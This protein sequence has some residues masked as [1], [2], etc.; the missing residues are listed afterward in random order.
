MAR[1]LV[2]AV[3]QP[4]Q[5]KQGFLSKALNFGKDLGVGIVKSL[6]QTV[7][8]QITSP[9]SPLNP[10][11]GLD[12]TGQA[13][14]PLIKKYIPETVKLPV[15]GETSLRYSP[16]PLKALGQTTEDLL[17]VATSGG[18]G[19]VGKQVAKQGFKEVVEQTAK[20][21]AKKIA[22]NVAM[23]FGVGGLYGASSAIQQKD[24]KPMDVLKSTLFGGTAG[25]LIPR[26]LGATVGTGLKATGIIGKKIAGVAD[27]AASKLEGFAESK[28]A[29]L[30]ER[31]YE[32]VDKPVQTTLQNAAAKTAGAIRI[33]QKT[34]DFLKKEFI[35][36]YNPIKNFQE[37][38]KAQGIDVPD[39]HDMAQSTG[40]RASGKAENK[41][42]DYL[43]LRQGSA[44]VWGK[45]KELAHYLDDLDRLERGNAIAGGRTKEQVTA[46]LQS[47][48][49]SMSP[50]EQA[51]VQKAY[52]ELQGFLKKE[53][54]D[55]SDSGRISP[56]QLAQIQA[57]HP[58]YIPHDVLDFVDEGEL[59]QQAGRSFNVAKSGVDKASGSLREIDDIDNAITR[60][61]FKNSLLN[62][63][64][65]TMAAIVETGGKMGFKPLRTAEHVQERNV[66]IDSLKQLRAER[67]RIRGSIGTVNTA[68]KGLVAK[69]NK[70]N[71]E[72]DDL[73]QK[74]INLFT[75]QERAENPKLIAELT[76]RTD[77]RPVEQAQQQGM[78]QAAVGKE[79]AKFLAR[80]AN[81]VQAEIN[82]TIKENSDLLFGTIERAP[83]PG[84]ARTIS[85]V[86]S[87]IEASQ[88]KLL[89]L[90]QER[91]RSLNPET[92]V[93]APK[94]SMKLENVGPTTKQQVKTLITSKNA[95]IEAIKNRIIAREQKLA[96]TETAKSGTEMMLDSLFGTLKQKRQQIADLHKALGPLRDVEA[97]AIDFK[98]AGFE[99]V[100]Y[101]KNGVREDWLV[102]SDLGKAL[103]GLDGEG[104]SAV[105]SWL[106][107]SWGGKFLTAPARA[108]RKVATGLEATFALVR[109]PARDVQTVMM[110]GRALPQDYAKGLASVIAGKGKKGDELYRLARE[111]GALQGSI[112]KE[113]E[114]PQQ[115]LQAKLAKGN[116]FSKIARPDKLIENAGQSMEEMTRMAVFGRAIKDGKTAQEAAKLARNST[117][118]FGKSGNTLQIINKVVPFLNARVQGFTN[119]ATKLAED[120]TKF[121]RRGMYSAAIPAA[122]LNGHNSQYKSYS[123][124]PSYEKD[125]YWVVMIG[126]SDGKDY[127]GK[128]VAI[129]HYLRIPKGEAQQAIASSVDRVLDMGKQKHPESTQ[130]FLARLVGNVSPVTGSSLLPTGIQQ[131]ADLRSNYS[132]FK[133][134]QIE[135]DY[136]K[137][138]GKSRPTSSIPAGQHVLPNTSEVAKY[139]GQALGW[140]PIKIDYVLKT[141]AINDIL[142]AI[143]IPVHG[144]QSSG[145]PFEKATELPYLR[146]FIGS[147]TA[148][149][150][151]DAKRGQQE[152]EAKKTQSLLDRA[153]QSSTFV[154]SGNARPLKNLGSR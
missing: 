91:E 63:K 3:K 107:N 11:R 129:P 149:A 145:T 86:G 55:A 117:V 57:A 29:G 56:E 38:A 36:K 74:A 103:K 82:K 83:T 21:G 139:L 47:L 50:E 13:T 58:N 51:S 40:Y 153:K 94:V 66:I 144:F 141:G 33:A 106:N 109:N 118:D 127:N 112:Y 122:M 147:S 95:E 116:I 41:L 136:L 75:T 4:E 85:A 110:T 128:P 6:G 23:D 32:A 49:Q 22:K 119:L 111:S 152:K 12:P 121:V 31:F 34:P 70:L 7:A 148:G 98:K 92:A 79:R 39:V 133:E 135:P 42:D 30:G 102:P 113:F 97:K 76:T 17:N 18:A 132:A 154:P 64:N 142:R 87:K 100:S 90:L 150:S 89:K 123:N 131:F 96:Q 134:K 45:T 37:K 15:F 101:F 26:V 53:L 35:D 73:S 124:I 108:L 16:Q 137:V 2:G 62:E 69:L 151:E 71:S 67:D 10:F 25:V 19:A 72:I 120:P 138:G 9:T 43:A 54:Q 1:P 65:R 44:P 27:S 59:A 48:R 99:K 77:V 81:T 93:V 68:D 146:S 61:L 60:R 8:R 84:E 20:Q 24:A 14:Q 88:N 126:E 115:I 114:T 143:D 105:M 78:I 130:T 5:Q 28:A 80:D 125:K 104:A 46:D 52:G 140:S